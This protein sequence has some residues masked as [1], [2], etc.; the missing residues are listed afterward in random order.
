[1]LGNSHRTLL[2]G[3]DMA[4]ATP[5]ICLCYDIGVEVGKKTVVL[6]FQF[7]DSPV[8]LIERNSGGGFFVK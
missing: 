1:M 4:Y 3:F 6:L 5:M 7:L 2:E 8:F